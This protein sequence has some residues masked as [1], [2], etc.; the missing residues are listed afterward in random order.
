MDV[1]E[2]LI[3]ALREMG[4]EGLYDSEGPC[5]CG[6]DDLAPC[7]ETWG[8]ILDRCIPAKRGEDGLYYP[9]EDQHNGTSK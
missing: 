5:G 3:K 1:E 6:I 2:I 8:E 9:M 4:A 7:G